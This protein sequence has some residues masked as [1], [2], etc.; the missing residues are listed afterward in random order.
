M[1]SDKGKRFEAILPSRKARALLGAVA[2]ALA[3]LM[4]G[5]SAHA[6]TELDVV[7]GAT[8]LTA[9]GSYTQNAAP[10]SGS[11]LTFTNSPY[12][13]A[14]FTVGGALGLGTLNDLS[15]TAL[16]ISGAGPITLSGGTNSVASVNGGAASDLLFVAAGG[17]LTVSGT[18]IVLTTTAANG[19]FN[20]AGSA[21][22]GGVLSGTGFGITKTGAGNLALT[23]TNTYT[24]ATVLSAGN[25]SIS[26]NANLGSVTVGQAPVTLSGGTLTTTGGITNT[27]AF[28]VG[29]NGGS[30]SVTTSAADT[31]DVGYLTLGAGVN[32]TV[33][34]LILGGVSQPAGTYGA[35]GSGAQFINNEFFAG[36]GILTATA[37]APE[38]ASLALL[39][40]AAA[41]L[42][43]RR[44]RRLIARA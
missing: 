39:G 2:A 1:H 15:A 40:L 34:G 11:D 21:T 42:L 28:T 30:I 5:R 29:S 38:P 20:V 3:S 35:S 9:A 17:S 27:H 24:G 7:N 22:L 36:T 33:G 37:S 10:T 41:G 44:R 23:G 13:A 6:G 26:A 43:G 8:D 25:V 18:P 19:N 12:S 4:C 16:T 32:E 31:A 14:A